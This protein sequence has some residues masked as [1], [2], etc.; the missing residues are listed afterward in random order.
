[1]NVL[2]ISPY[3]NFTWGISKY[4][5]ILFN[6]FKKRNDI[7]LYFLTNGGDALDRLKALKIE[8]LILNFKTGIQNVFYLNRNLKDLKKICLEKNIQI[9]HTHHRYPELLANLLKNKIN[10]KTI[11]TVHSLVKGFSS[12]SFKSDKIIAVCKAVEKN[13]I[14]NFNIQP[15]R[16]IQLYNP[17]LITPNEDKISIRKL[18]EELGLNE[19]DRVF[20]YVGRFHKEKGIDILVN[21]FSKLPKEF[22]NLKIILITDIGSKAKKYYS[23]HSIIFVQPQNDISVFYQLADCVVQPSRMDSFPYSMLEAGYFEKIFIGGNT[24]GI[25]EFIENRV[26]GFLVNPDEN[27]LEIIVR[28]LMQKPLEHYA[29]LGKNLRRKVLNLPPPELY[30]DKLI[31]IYSQLLNEN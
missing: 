8:P 6:E 7:K 14:L 19:D 15:N 27:D 2:H 17:I 1:M 13:L 4:L 10:I 3:F 28:D 26:N 25:A 29:T 23:N 5:F 31:Q 22:S 24:G 9:I 30:A 11:T 18:R 20:L 16:I 12:L 21:V